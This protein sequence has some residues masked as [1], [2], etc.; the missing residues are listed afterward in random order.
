VRRFS[1]RHFRKLKG[2]ELENSLLEAIEEWRITA[3]DTHLT[4]LYRLQTRPASY[5]GVLNWSFLRYNGIR[6]SYNKSDATI[7]GGSFA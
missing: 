4:E 5:F 1:S 7:S 6:S 2:E 3:G